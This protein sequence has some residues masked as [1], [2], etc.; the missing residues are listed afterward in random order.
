MANV[1]TRASN[2]SGIVGK[3]FPYYYKPFYLGNATD[4]VGSTDGAKYIS[5]TTGTSALLVEGSCTHSYNCNF[6]YELVI[7]TDSSDFFYIKKYDL[8]G[9]LIDTIYASTTSGDGRYWSDA[10]VGSYTI[11]AGVNITI[12]HTTNFDNGDVYK[13][14]L[15]TYEEMERRKIY[16]GG[17]STFMQLAET[18]GK[19]YHSEIIP[20]NL[21]G[22]GISLIWNPP[23]PCGALETVPLPGQATG[24]MGCMSREDEGGNKACS[25]FLEWNSDRDGVT[26]STAG[27][28]TDGYG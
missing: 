19:A 20:K 22:K 9:T 4:G 14:T 3:W 25:I 23:N 10:G 24:L 21:K 1:G 7:V 13:I 5:Q 16:H 6:Y 27:N 8:S 17:F 15:P 26:D 12:P 28:A 11:D 18:E 2:A